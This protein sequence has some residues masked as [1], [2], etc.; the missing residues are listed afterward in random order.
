[1][2]LRSQKKNKKL[3]ISCFGWP[4]CS[5][6][7]WFSD[8][9]KEVKVLEQKCNKCRNDNKNL[10]IKFKSNTFLATL[11]GSLINDEDQT[12]ISC[13][14]CDP[15]LRD[16]LNITDKLIEGYFDI[17]P[18]NQNQRTNVGDTPKCSICEG[19]VIK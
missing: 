19:P 16:V 17:F 3:F 13:I 4:K 6:A 5:Y 9:I 12:Y 2:G 11:N 7:I 15:N 18:Q 14:L 1:M 10:A 8:I